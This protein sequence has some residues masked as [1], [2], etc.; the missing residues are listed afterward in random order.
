MFSKSQK[1]WFGMEGLEGRVL[2]SAAVQV[3]TDPGMDWSP[4]WS[5]G[6][7]ALLF[8]SDRNDADGID[9][10]SV[11]AAGGEGAA[12][13]AAV[14]ATA[15]SEQSA[16]YNAAGTK[17]AFQRSGD[18]GQ[19]SIWTANADGTGELQVAA[20]GVM[21]S[22]SPDG[23]KIVFSDQ[24]D[25][26]TVK[27]NGS[28]LA[29]LYAGAG[30]DL[31]PAWSPDG[32]KIAFTSNAGGDWAIWTIHSD[33]TGA[34][35]L[36]QSS[37]SGEPDWRPDSGEIAFEG[38][39]GHLW[40]ISPQDSGSLSTLR[41]ITSYPAWDSDPTWSPDG[42]KIAFTSNRSG[43]SDLWVVDAS[44]EGYLTSVES[45]RVLDYAAPGT[46]LD[47]RRRLD[48]AIRGIGITDIHVTTPWGESF[49]SSGL[50]PAAWNG[51]SWI[52]AARGALEVEGYSDGSQTV[53][54]LSWGRLTDGQWS[55]LDAGQVSITVSYRGGQ[56]SSTLDFSGLSQPL[57]DPGLTAPLNRQIAPGNLSAQWAAWSGAPAGGDVHVVIDEASV[58]GL[59]DYC[60]PAGAT[61]TT[62]PQTLADSAYRME[63]SF[64][65]GASSVVGGVA[66][67]RAASASSSAFFVVGG[68]GDDYGNSPATAGH[69]AVPS[70]FGGGLDYLGDIDFFSFS[71]VAGQTYEV[72]VGL[73]DGGLSDSA[74]WLYGPDGKTALAWDDDGGAG[75]GSRLLWTAPLSGTYYLAVDAYD[76]YDRLGAYTVQIAPVAG[77]WDTPS[78]TLGIAAGGKL[79]LDAQGSRGVAVSQLHFGA[80]EVDGW[81]V[82]HVL[83]MSNPLAASEIG[84]YAISRLAATAGFKAGSNLYYLADDGPGGSWVDSTGSG[85]AELVV[86]NVGGGGDPTVVGRTPIALKDVDSL[87]IQGNYLYVGT[88][89]ADASQACLEIYDISGAGSPVLVGRSAL[90]AGPDGSSFDP[91]GLVVQGGRAYLLHSR[92]GIVSILNVAN[93]AAPVLLGQYTAASDPAG[94]PSTSMAL[95]GGLL[96]I[97]VGRELSGIDV[98]DPAHPVQAASLGL[99][100]R[101]SQIAA[102]GAELC[103]GTVG[104]GV[105]FVDIANPHSPELVDHY[106]VAGSSGAL[107]MNGGYI[108]VPTNSSQ[109]DAF[110]LLKGT[111]SGFVYDDSGNYDGSRQAGEPGIGGVTITLSG[112]D[113]KGPV[114]GS[115]VTASDGSYTFAGLRPGTYAVSES[116]QPAGYL[117]GLDAKGGAAI[118]GSNV[119][120]TIPGIV[121]AAGGASANDNFGELSPAG[122]S[123]FVYDDSIDNDGVK[124]AGQQGL[125]G[126]TITLSGVDDKGPVSGSTTTASDGSYTFAGLRPGT[127]AVGE[128]AQP[129][130]Y[131]DGLDARGGAVIP[132]SNLT[133]TIP[134]I[135]LA[136]GGTSANDNFGE[137]SFIP[138][139]P[140]SWVTT[141]SASQGHADIALTVE[142]H[143]AVVGN[144]GVTSVDVYVSTDGGAYVLAAGNVGDAGALYVGQPGHTYRFYSIATDEVG[145]HEAAPQTP[146]A[147]VALW[148]TEQ[149]VLGGRVTRAARIDGDGTPI[150]LSYTGPGTATVLR[151]S[152]PAGGRGD[153]YSVSITGSSASSRLGI[154]TTGAGAKGRTSIGDITVSGPLGAISAGTTNLLGDVTVDGSLGTLT[155]ANVS[156][157]GTI[158]IGPAASAGAAVNMTF[159]QVRDLS[160][161]S[162]MPI[163]TL[164]ATEWLDLAAPADLIQ[165]PRIGTLTAS[166]R[167]ANTRLGVTSLAGDFQASLKL[168]DASA[169]Q[170]LGTVKIAG[171]VG[172]EDWDVAGKVGAVTIGGSVGLPGGPAG[173]WDLHGATGLA[174]LRTGNIA[175]ARLDIGGDIGTLTAKSWLAGSITAQSLSSL[176]VSGDFGAQVALTLPPAAPSYKQAMGTAKI[177]G[178]LTDSAWTISGKA[179]SITA[180]G[181]VNGFSLGGGAGELTA[182]ATLSLGDVGNASVDVHGSMG[183]IAAKSWAAGTIHA[184][185]LAGLTI[186]SSRPTPAGDF[187]ADLTLDGV[188]VASSSTLGSV[189]IAGALT[190]GQWDVTGKVGAISIRYI[191]APLL[192]PNAKLSSIATSTPLL[193]AT[194]NG[195][196]QY[197]LATGD[198][199]ATYPIQFASLATWPKTVGDYVIQSPG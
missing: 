84:T 155:L 188:S 113:D 168:T 117:D 88:Q 12:P 118:P 30:E 182:L 99:D 150:A 149:I 153:L 104:A 109:I 57:Q 156:G 163:G 8:S 81:S 196:K 44:G 178:H 173:A 162:Q 27:A 68:A 185:T 142:A 79:T 130:G 37:S 47:D 179:G 29:L 61:S 160:I 42:A 152:N 11:G 7:G 78:A 199:G 193:R 70:T 38:S 76:V 51:Q 140:R 60:L 108:Y 164:K 170:T 124:Q 25:L 5:P 20:S 147:T 80:S 189:N 177:T 14:V 102:F 166:G 91:D 10:Y 4:D 136:A 165:A 176:T 21:P 92:T 15:A 172:G 93:P 96:W 115:T 90:I 141:P 195:V 67:R 75:A 24:G 148:P 74:A 181:Q 161:V 16:R 125:S 159:D 22:W 100:A 54:N 180:S 187:G 137:V 131:L 151:W 134:G 191:R 43:N 132:G 48:L 72:K 194:Q 192:M 112:V 190:G 35:Q 73:S 3:T 34:K 175:N 143:A 174:S 26:W 49:D 53:L 95:A 135:V 50:I 119:T 40:A 17:I 186:G 184:Y 39:D 28:G 63:V 127:Y 145:S 105:R 89:S 59:Y 55:S 169:R 123:G 33:G 13:A 83:D 158:R 32:T 126:V 129:A 56:W 2:L 197:L 64:E 65:N 198:G 23:T 103:V 62:P 128:P 101:V 107:S 36:V 138:T 120:D 157:Q 98:S 122:L 154:A 46:A 77:A 139:P 31:C 110:L 86:L 52:N 97:G 171:S 18:L 69:I 106:N 167:L 144:L 9:I 116:A 45:D 133:D 87:A 1:A 121:L 58:A 94:L 66:V 41:Q 146:D 71:A 85:H 114:S 6:G 183:R 19:S 82:L 111:L